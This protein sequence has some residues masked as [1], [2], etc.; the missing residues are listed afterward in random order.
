MACEPCSG[1]LNALYRERSHLLA[2]LAT[3]YPSHLQYGSDP[4]APGWPVLY[5][6]L[7]TGQCC[8]HLSE[9]DLDLFTHV[10]TDVLETWDGHSTDEKY[11]RVDHAT[12]IKAF[13]G[14]VG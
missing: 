13:G 2:H 12:R 9:N 3:L 7:P 14:W 10:R 1:E 5:I 8:W 6:S 11:E 4:D